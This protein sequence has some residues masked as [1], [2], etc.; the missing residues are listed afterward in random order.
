MFDLGVCPNTGRVYEGNSFSGI[1]L[2]GGI[3]L[4]PIKVIGHEIEAGSCA[5]LK[6]ASVIFREDSF[7]PITKVRRGR[8]YK[9]SG[10]QPSDWHVQDY[11]RKDLPEVNNINAVGFYQRLERASHYIPHHIQGADLVRNNGI[12]HIG[13]ESNLSFWKVLFVEEQF[14]GS[15]LLTL[16]ATKSFGLIPELLDRNIPQMAL[17]SLKD[18][19]DKIDISAGRLSAVDTVDRCRDALSIVFGAL[20]ENM[21]LDLGKG[22]NAYRAK[23]LGNNGN[24]LITNAADVVRRLHSR[25]KPSEKEAYSTRALTDE[26]AD[27][28][29]NSLW[30]VLVELGWAR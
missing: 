5:N 23:E 8:I 14:D 12:V 22:V 21:K 7:D 9:L 25:G 6:F 30:F 26:D 17:I 18:V 28:A 1:P 27:L 13:A 15:Q 2:T 24:N 3:K 19:L 4:F 10:S 11:Q 29:L 20:A 16:K